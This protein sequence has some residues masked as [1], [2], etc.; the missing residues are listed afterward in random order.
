MALV[1][2]VLGIDVVDLVVHIVLDYWNWIRS[3]E[4]IGMQSISKRKSRPNS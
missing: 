4:R 3:A 2:V 1:Y